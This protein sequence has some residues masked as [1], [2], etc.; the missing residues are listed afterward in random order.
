MC[1]AETMRTPKWVTSRGEAIPLALMSDTHVRAVMRYLITGV[2]DRGPMLRTGCSGFSNS[3]WLLLCAS[4][5]LRR[6]M[7]SHW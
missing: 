6:S 7:F 1:G 4:E 3:E 2:G 5:L